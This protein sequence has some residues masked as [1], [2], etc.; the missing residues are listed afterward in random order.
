MNGRSELLSIIVPVCN[1]AAIVGHLIDTLITATLAI[2]R[3]ILVIDEG[4]TD[5]TAEVLSAALDDGV[6][7][8]VIETVSGGS[9]P[10]GVPLGLAQA[11]GSIV[12]IHMARAAISSTGLAALVAALRS[13]DVDAVYGS[14]PR[15][16]WRPMSRTGAFRS[17]VLGTIANWVVGASRSGRTTGAIVMRADLART[18]RLTASRAEIAGQITA[19]LLANGHRILELPLDIPS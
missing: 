3:E 19:R 1:E 10:A 2:E 5:G 7:I 9:A 11:H 6:A 15:P 12:L 18:L 17:G 8:E 4:S 16:R 13:G 14:L